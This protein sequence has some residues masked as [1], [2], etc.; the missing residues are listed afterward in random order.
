MPSAGKRTGAFFISPGQF[1]PFAGVVRKVL[2]SCVVKWLPSAAD[3]IEFLDN[4]NASQVSRLVLITVVLLSNFS[5]DQLS[6]RIV[7]NKVEYFEEIPIVKGHFTLTKVENTGAFLSVGNSLPAELK[8]IL[9]A[10]LPLL[11]LSIATLYLFLNDRLTHLRIAGICFLIGG[12]MGNIIDRL[13]YG[14]VTDFLHLQVGRFQT[15]VF[16]MA[17][18]S[19]VIGLIMILISSRRRSRQPM[20]DSTP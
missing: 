4:M 8:V 10:I 14:S 2:A 12:G 11:A 19:I 20:S 9:L 13:F 16:N 5:C 3:S 1:F 7:R 15:G 18:V 17:D 6:K